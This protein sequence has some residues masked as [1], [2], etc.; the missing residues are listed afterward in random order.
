LSACAALS[1]EEVIRS[2]EATSTAVGADRGFWAEGV[3]ARA[4]KVLR[5]EKGVEAPTIRGAPTIASAAAAGPAEG[6]EVGRALA[7][8]GAEAAAVG[9]LD[10]DVALEGEDDAIAVSRRADLTIQINAAM[11]RMTAAA[12]KR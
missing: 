11:A 1:R 3:R 2:A 12:P 7:V 8:G 5:A 9:K 10:G 4:V 6:S